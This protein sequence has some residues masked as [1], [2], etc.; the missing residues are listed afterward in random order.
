MRIRILIGT[1]IVR[2][3][4]VINYVWLIYLFIRIHLSFHQLN[5]QSSTSYSVFPTWSTWMLY[6]HNCIFEKTG[7]S[8]G[9]FRITFWHTYFKAGMLNSN[10]HV[11]KIN[12]SECQVSCILGFSSWGSRY[13]LIRGERWEKKYLHNYGPSRPKRN[14]QASTKTEEMLNH[15]WTQYYLHIRYELFDQTRNGNIKFRLTLCSQF[16]HS[17]EGHGQALVS[18]LANNWQWTTGN[19]TK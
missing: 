13:E 10:K 14:G 12:L 19:H 15:Q 9:V 1:T 18:G 17:H 7:C 8:P 5:H 11:W 3:A 2:T 6:Q 4:T 16:R